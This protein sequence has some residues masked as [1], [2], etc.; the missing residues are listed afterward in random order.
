MN[1]DLLPTTLSIP[2]AGRLLGYGRDTSYAA[3]K[4]GRLPTIL[5][6]RKKRRVPTHRLLQLLD[7]TTEPKPGT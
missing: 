1:T 2:E 4:D 6:G 5:I 7:G 3:A